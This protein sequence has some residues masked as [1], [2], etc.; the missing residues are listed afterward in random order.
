MRKYHGYMFRTVAAFFV[1]LA[2]C[3]IIFP[4][5]ATAKGK[6]RIVYELPEPEDVAAA[7]MIHQSEVAE[8]VAQIVE[9]WNL[10]S[11]DVVLRFGTQ[12]GPHFTVLHNGKLEI[13]I[14]YEFFSNTRD[15]FTSKKYID[16]KDPITSALNTLHHAIYHELGHAVIY[17]QSTGIAEKM[18]ERAVDNLS[19]ILLISA[20]ENG[21]DIAASAAKAFQLLAT[22][23]ESTLNTKN[24]IRRVQEINC[25]IYGNNPNKYKE[26]LADL[27]VNSDAICPPRFRKYHKQWEQIFNI[28]LP[29]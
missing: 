6:L 22:E 10:L 16:Q 21:A 19:A 3:A 12:I 26:L 17:S 14:P 27:P 28:P 29:D 9:E 20:Y 25:L 4:T 23:S 1:L 2:S 5:A 18:E 7:R 11:Q 15:L 13:Q 8:E 24:D